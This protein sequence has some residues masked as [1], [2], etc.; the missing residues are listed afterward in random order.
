MRLMVP[1]RS[2][3]GR[4]TGSALEPQ[5]DGPIRRCRWRARSFDPSARCAGMGLV[6]ARARLLPNERDV[7]RRSNKSVD[8]DS[9]EFVLAERQASIT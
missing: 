2:D 7:R 9:T 8:R 1:R 5:Q 6:P 4:R 3:Y